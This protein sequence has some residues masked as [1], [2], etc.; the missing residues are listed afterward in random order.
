MVPLFQK[1]VKDD[2]LLMGQIMEK[3]EEQS[4]DYF[5]LLR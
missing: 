3:L 1:E 4:E 2:E 5:Q